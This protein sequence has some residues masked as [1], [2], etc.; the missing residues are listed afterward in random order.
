MVRL[1]RTAYSRSPHVR[2]SSGHEDSLRRS[3][4]S[5]RGQH[6]EET[7]RLE[8]AERAVRGLAYPFH[9]EV[10]PF[11]EAG[12]AVRITTRRLLGGDEHVTT[13]ATLESV[14]YYQR[15]TWRGV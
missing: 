12:Y 13:C 3:R 8:E 10:V 4:G 2:L 5:G 11:G 7:M 15:S 6:G 14:R 9:G 1:A